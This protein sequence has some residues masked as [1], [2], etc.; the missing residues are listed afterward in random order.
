[1]R[2]PEE[3][4]RL[5]GALAQ[6]LECGD[7]LLLSG[8]LGAGKTHFARALIR[9]LTGNSEEEVP[10]PTF[11]LVQQYER[12]QG[13]DI[14]HFDLYRLQNP[15]EVFELGIED[16]FEHGISLIE[17]PERM[18]KLIPANALLLTLA[19]GGGEEERHIHL[20]GTGR[21]EKKVA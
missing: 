19:F 8:P 3:T 14:W 17:W 16:A 13:P 12:A 6:K 21:W 2:A 10:S 9:S 18:E 5:A 15:D 11:T 4:A 20:Q 1:M 7:V